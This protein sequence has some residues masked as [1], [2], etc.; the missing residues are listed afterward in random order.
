MPFA[1]E[2]D[3]TTKTYR[4]KNTDSSFNYVSTAAFDLR[5]GLPIAANDVNGARQETDVDNFGRPFQVFGPKT[6]T[7]TRSNDNR[8]SSSVTPS[9]RTW[10]PASWR[11]CLRRQRR[12]T[13]TSHR[14]EMSTTGDPLSSRPPI[15]TVAFTD[16]LQ[17]IIQTKKGHH[18]R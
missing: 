17:R 16:G 1:Y 6:S 7:G 8:A 12:R 11:R 5:F 15:T 10:P 18:A 14:P 9:S 3:P 4:T 13:R 2:F